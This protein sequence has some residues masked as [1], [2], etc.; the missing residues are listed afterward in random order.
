MSHGSRGQKSTIRVP[1][2]SGPGEAPSGLQMLSSHWVL[3]WRK[4]RGSSVGSL[5]IRALIPFTGAPPGHLPKAPPPNSIPPG[6]RFKHVSLGAQTPA[7][8]TVSLCCCPFSSLSFSFSHLCPPLK[9]KGGEQ[10]KQRPPPP[11]PGCGAACQLLGGRGFAF[12]AG[13]P[14]QPFSSVMGSKGRP[15]P[16][17]GRFKPGAA[18][19]S[20]CIPRTKS[21]TSVLPAHR[22][23]RLVDGTVAGAPPALPLV[24]TC[25][26]RPK[27]QLAHGEGC[28]RAQE[29]TLRDCGW[30]G[31]P[32]LGSGG[33]HTQASL[34]SLPQGVTQHTSPPAR[35]LPTQQR[36]CS[37][38][39]AAFLPKVS[40]GGWSWG[41]LW[42][43]PKFQTPGG[44][45]GLSVHRSVYTKD[46]GS[47]SHPCRL[48]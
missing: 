39:C 33:I 12:S 22:R 4:G 7:K 20:L 3:T 43:A 38:T 1:V 15:T 16:G 46:L 24:E 29:G 35:P 18:L 28:Y 44:K 9:D 27:V 26:A 6:L 32:G 41:R 10:P 19:L 8:C 23:P 5:L 2:C 30:R 36:K 31:G 25:Q 48:G 42:R 37:N 45:Q 47:V 13:S 11:P 40:T 17:P 34:F 21:R 14:T